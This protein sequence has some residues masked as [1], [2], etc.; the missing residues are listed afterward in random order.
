MK[1]H[2][3]ISYYIIHFFLF[4]IT[5]LCLIPVINTIAISFSSAFAANTGQ[6]YFWPVQ[7]T[8]SPYRLLLADNQF[9]RTFGISLVRVVAGGIINILLTIMMAYPLSKSPNIFKAK[10]RYMWFVVFLWVFPPGMIPLFVLVNNMGMIN[11]IWALVLPGA[12]PIFSVI[13]LMNFFKGIPGEMEESALIDG[14]GQWRI[15]WQIFVPLAKP[16]IAVIALWAVVFHWNDFFSGLIYFTDRTMWP[17]QT[18]IQS[19]SL[20]IDHNTIQYMDPQTLQ[21]VWETTGIT[22]NSARVVIAMIP[23]LLVYPFL[24]RYFVKGIVMGAVKG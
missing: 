15:M 17:L 24:Q 18:Y 14:A 7:F 1:H 11:T 10:T 21:A 23:V 13:V 16:S 2:K 8:L 22:F 6:V 20:T 12:V 19:L 4:L 5:A 9:F 3:N